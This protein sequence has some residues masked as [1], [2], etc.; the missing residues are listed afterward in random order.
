MVISFRL[1]LLLDLPRRFFLNLPKSKAMWLLNRQSHLQVS[2]AYVEARDIEQP[3]VEA[4]RIKEGN[5]NAVDFGTPLEARTLT[6]SHS[7]VATPHPQPQT[8]EVNQRKK[9]ASKF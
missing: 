9:K 2:S 3:P 1:T 6:Q 4:L 5:R 8:P 7:V